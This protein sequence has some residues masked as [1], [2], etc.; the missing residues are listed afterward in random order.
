MIRYPSIH[1][2]GTPITE[3]PH[4]VSVSSPHR[5]GIAIS[6]ACVQIYLNGKSGLRSKVGEQAILLNIGTLI[7]GY[8]INLPNFTVIHNSLFLY[9][10]ASSS[11]LHPVSLAVL[12]ACPVTTVPTIYRASTS[13]DSI[14]RTMLII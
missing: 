5:L 4:L 11:P 2:H 10:D 1:Q 8:N 13:L 9:C 7:G 12:V 14:V 6:T 3:R